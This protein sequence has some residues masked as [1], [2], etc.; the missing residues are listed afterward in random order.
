MLRRDIVGAMTE[1]FNGRN[2]GCLSPVGDP[3]HT[4]EKRKAR[5]ECDPQST[6]RICGRIYPCDAA[7]Q[8][9]GEQTDNPKDRIRF[10]ENT[11]RPND[12]WLAGQCGELFATVGRCGDGRKK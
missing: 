9:R 5:T 7:E 10:H 6:G 3:L 2:I 12:D 4:D 8:N 11:L 1:A